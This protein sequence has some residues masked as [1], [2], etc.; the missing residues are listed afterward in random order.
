MSLGNMEDI[1]GCPQQSFTKTWLELAQGQNLVA[2][3]PWTRVHL[4]APVF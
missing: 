2:L 3:I 1:Y 4:K